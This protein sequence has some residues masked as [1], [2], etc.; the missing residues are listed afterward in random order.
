MSSESA[1][2]VYEWMLEMIKTREKSD[3]NESYSC[4]NT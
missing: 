3:E 1:K 4:S 2:H